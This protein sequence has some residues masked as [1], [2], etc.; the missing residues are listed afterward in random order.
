MSSS[1]TLPEIHQ[2]V[3]DQV[4]I[5]I[6]KGHLSAPYIEIY[7]SFSND[8]NVFYYISNLDSPGSENKGRYFCFI[9][10]DEPEMT[11]TELFEKGIVSDSNFQEN[12]YL[13]D[14]SIYWMLA[15]RQH[16][17]VQTLIKQ[18]KPQYYYPTEYPE[19]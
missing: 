17:N 13:G 12:E 16:E 4:K 9:E 3:A 19:L 5:L 1:S 2:R 11:R 8:S 15:L 14:S 7:E 18:Q 6:D 10:L